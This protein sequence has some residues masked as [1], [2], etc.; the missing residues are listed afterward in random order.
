MYLG[1]DLVAQVTSPRS[2]K[3]TLTYEQAAVQRF[4]V[5]SMAL[6]A[7]LPVRS[8]RYSP[9]EVAPFLEGLLP[10]GWARAGLEQ[11]FDVH[12]VDSLALLAV[13]GR[14]CAGAVSVVPT[15]EP[16]PAAAAGDQAQRLL[17][18][19]AIAAR[20]GALDA[21]PFGVDDAT[22]ISLAG[23]PWKLPL[24]R[25]IG[26]GWAAPGPGVWSTHLV[27][28]E[29]AAFV[30]LVATEAFALAALR[31][32]GVR[33]VSAEAATFGARP[34]LV[35]ERFDRRVGPDGVTTRI[36][37]EDTCQALGAPRAERGERDGGPS[38]A[39]VAELVDDMTSDPA[40]EL[41]HL[42]QWVTA[43]VVFGKVDGTAR[44]LALTYDDGECRLAPIASMAGTADYPERPRQMDLSVGGIDDLDRIGRPQLVNEA[45]RWGMPAGIAAAVIDGLAADLDATLDGARSVVEPGDDVVRAC[46]SRLAALA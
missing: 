12:R 32:A 23:T 44:D 43:G 10:D 18:D 3:L 37:Q 45:G 39:E 31:G 20:L 19:A 15:G 1:D 6:S 25:V 35:V 5:G 38:L 7:S 33:V 17:D 16:G 22:R 28:P 26:G 30:G 40:A 42:L 21:D 11:R 41:A 24:A 14:E 46:R 4:G 8:E 27:R 2:A 29:P 9:S 13:I 34:A 36:H